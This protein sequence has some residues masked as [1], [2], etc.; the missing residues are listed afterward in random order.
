M[1][2]KRTRVLRIL[3]TVLVSLPIMAALLP[4][5]VVF[6]LALLALVVPL[7]VLLAPVAVWAV[8]YWLTRS[9]PDRRGDKRSYVSRLARVDV[10]R[11]VVATS[12]VATTVVAT[13]TQNL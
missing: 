2:P 4:D 6:S 5:I 13:T 3:A 10:A 12:V 8:G 11:A 9:K 1:S 7:L